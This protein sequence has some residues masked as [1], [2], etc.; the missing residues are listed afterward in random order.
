MDTAKRRKKRCEIFKAKKVQK[1]QK[2]KKDEKAITRSL[3][4]PN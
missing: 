4:Q 3:Y 1:S 2:K